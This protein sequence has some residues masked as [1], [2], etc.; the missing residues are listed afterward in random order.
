MAD[1]NVTSAATAL[2]PKATDWL[3]TGYGDTMAKLVDSDIVEAFEALGDI[4]SRHAT[5]RL[6]SWDGN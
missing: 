5:R 3:P 2:E 6:W 4:A 1:S